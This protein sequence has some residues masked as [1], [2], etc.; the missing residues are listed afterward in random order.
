[1]QLY[2]KKIQMR[3]KKRT[4]GLHGSEEN[5]DKEEQ[6]MGNVFVKLRVGNCSRSALYLVSLSNVEH[7]FMC[8][9]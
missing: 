4:N 3:K 2:S 1:M 8:I 6:H 7:V 9:Y 5:K